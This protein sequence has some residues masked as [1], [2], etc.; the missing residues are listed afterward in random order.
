MPIVAI[1]GPDGAGK[2]TIV[3]ALRSK[4]DCDYHK[5]SYEPPDKMVHTLVE[6]ISRARPSRILLCDRLHYPD[7]I[8]YSRAV[9]NIPS[10]LE[11][12]VPLCEYVLRENDTFL[13]YVNAGLHVL[14]LRLLARGD[15]YVKD[16]SVLPLI[17]RYYEDFLSRTRLPY[18]VI[19]TSWADPETVAERAEMYIAERWP[20]LY[21]EAL[22]HE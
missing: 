12:V 18:K 6:V 13:L 4:L 14:K 11:F 2:T 16:L 21:K 22:K 9:R 20:R 10:T 8:V 7:D 5:G 3:E 15:D 19:D 17:Q 1:V